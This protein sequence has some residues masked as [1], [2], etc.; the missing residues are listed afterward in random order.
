M[1]LGQI[2]ETI[3]GQTLDRFCR[4]RIFTPLG[5]GALSF[6]DLT[7][8]RAGSSALR[9]DQIAATQRCAWRRRV[10]CGEVGDE[11]AY[12]MGGVAGHAGLFGTA[13][14][15]DALAG[16]FESGLHEEGGLLSAAAIR[17]MWTRDAGVADSTRTVGWDTPSP[18]GSS[19]G[20]RMSSWTVGHLGFTGTSIW[21]D[22]ERRIRIILLTNR[23][24]PD[25]DN[26]RLKELRPVIH[27]LVMEALG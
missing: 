8:M 12:A 9:S 4:T 11:N 16:A 10:L 25:R 21:M 2:V 18:V 20:S 7:Q 27:D 6:I 19:A 23:V 15:V 14:D 5:L 26:Q 17:E 1:V 24:H 3:S 13:R 22:L